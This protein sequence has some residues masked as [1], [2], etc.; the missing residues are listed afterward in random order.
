MEAPL[1]IFLVLLLLV[2]P[3]L[4]IIAFVGMRRLDETLRRQ[5]PQELTGRMYALEQRLAKLEKFGVAGSP[6][7]TQ[8]QVAI[9][10]P[11]PPAAAPSTPPPKPSGLA[12]ASQPSLTGFAPPPLHTSLPRDSDSTDLETVIAGRWFNRIGIVALLVAISYFL[13]LAFDN[14]WIGPSGRVMIGILLG[15]AMMPWSS[16]LLGRGYSYFS[17]GIVALGEATLFLSVWAGCSYYTLYSRD[18]CF[19]G[20][21]L[22]TSA[23]AAIALGRDSQ[24]IAVLC[25]IGGY[26][27]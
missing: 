9:A 20:M 21:I 2:G 26:L 12:P 17:E 25:L 22:I 19:F 15:A 8:P 1:I 6:V 10:P 13:K 27:R 3:I 14:N 23:M 11:P 7:T 4:G 16:W 24:R 18:V 5:N